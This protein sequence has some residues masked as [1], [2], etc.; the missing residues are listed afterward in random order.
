MLVRAP[1]SDPILALIPSAKTPFPNT[2][3]T[4][5]TEVRPRTFC[6]DR[7]Y[8]KVC[9]A[10]HVSPCVNAVVKEPTEGHVEDLGLRVTLGDSPRGSALCT[11]RREKRGT[12][13]WE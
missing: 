11:N 8:Q 1:L 3:V 10:G 2:I 7:L 6:G 4:M 13:Y 5:G 12:S 9:K